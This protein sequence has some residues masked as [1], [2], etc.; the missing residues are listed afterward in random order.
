MDV[1][2]SCPSS[3]HPD[4]VIRSWLILTI[5]VKQHQFLGF[6]MT[7]AKSN[8]EAQG[9]IACCPSDRPDNMVQQLAG[10]DKHDVRCMCAIDRD[11]KTLDVHCLS[12]FLKLPNSSMR[13]GSTGLCFV[14]EDKCHLHASHDVDRRP[15]VG[16]IRYLCQRWPYRSRYKPS[17]SPA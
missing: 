12:H 14:L 16:R 10:V 9:K 17:S 2:R 1:L 3:P 8:I 13:D 7:T 6:R 5:V 4:V 11:P 15:A